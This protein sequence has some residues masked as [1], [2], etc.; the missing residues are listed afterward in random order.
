[1]IELVAHN[2]PNQTSGIGRYYRELYH[3]LKDRIDVRMAF[4]RFLPLSDRL[5]ILQNFPLGVI[6]HKPGNIVHFT[7]ITG[8][9]QLLWNHT[10]PVIATVHD[11]GFL[12]CREDE[13][14][15]NKIDKLLLSLHIRGLQKVDHII[16][17]S[18]KTK[19]DLIGELGIAEY[20]IS[21][22]PSSVN[23]QNFRVIDNPFDFV[24][25]KYQLRKKRG[26][27]DL[28]YVG[29]ELPRKNIGVILES[30]AILKSWGINARL[31]KIGASGGIKWRDLFRQKIKELNLEGH[32]VIL[33]GVPEEELP[34]L[35]N[36][37][38]IAVT[39]TLLEGGFAWTVMEAMACGKPAIASDMALVPDDALGVV[40][41]VHDKEPFSY[42][43]KI[44]E[45]AEKTEYNELFRTQAR[46]II[47][48]YTWSNEAAETI[49]IYQ[50]IGA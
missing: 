44:R 12:V 2:P 39:A 23:L 46:S 32:V 47:S 8:C 24:L 10:H 30:V 6:D 36:F 41:V 7:Q 4:P 25:S 42:A 35:Y 1:M 21:I 22:V 18:A 49:R 17:H 16:V 5:T 9:S 28:I 45:F 27:L 14:L 43:I 34:Y 40:E 19:N 20:S 3:H 29:S 38:D 11:L 15:F 37:A 48:K 50:K 33:E 31:I 13:Q 26:L